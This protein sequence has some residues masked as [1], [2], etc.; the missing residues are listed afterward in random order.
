MY[1][2]VV[3]YI[4]WSGRV[5]VYRKSIQKALLS[6]QLLDAAEPMCKDVFDHETFEAEKITHRPGADL[7]SDEAIHALHT[8]SVM[9]VLG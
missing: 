9:Q 1:Y 5:A 4:T 6:C 8:Q 7:G 3:P 2:K